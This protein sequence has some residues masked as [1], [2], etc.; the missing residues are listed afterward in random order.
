MFS[1]RSIS[2]GRAGALGLVAALTLAFSCAACGA[3][4]DASE[5]QY[6]AMFKQTT[7]DRVQGT[8]FWGT[9]SQ[10][11]CNVGSGVEVCTPINASET[12]DAK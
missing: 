4:H 8:E 3:A 7:R 12:S 1:R 6:G 11:D 9:R 5:P 10:K 2:H